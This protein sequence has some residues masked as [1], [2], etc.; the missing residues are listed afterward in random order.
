MLPLD[1]PQVRHILP[2]PHSP[3]ARPDL[4]YLQRSSGPPLAIKLP[5][6]NVTCAARLSAIRRKINF[7]DAVLVQPCNPP[8]CF[9]RHTPITPII[10]APALPL[11][12]SPH[13]ALWVTAS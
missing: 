12:P 5:H 8:D 2:R 4:P 6:P 10:S 7:P 13:S 9:P 3:D 11:T 1:K